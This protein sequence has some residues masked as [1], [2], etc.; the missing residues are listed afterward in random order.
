MAINQIKVANEAKQDIT[1]SKTDQILGRLADQTIIANTVK[2]VQ[3]GIVSMGSKNSATG[4]YEFATVNPVGD[5][6]VLLIDSS[7]QYNSSMVAES[8]SPKFLYTAELIGNKICSEVVTT[9]YAIYLQRFKW[10]LI[11]FY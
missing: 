6:Y 2:S 7:S 4:R 11:E 8:N 10:T 5:K 3:R 9:T 1:I